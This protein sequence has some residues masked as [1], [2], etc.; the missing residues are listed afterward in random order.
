MAKVSFTKLG[1]KINKEIKKI[2]IKEQEV[3]IKQYL[4]INDKLTLVGNV[5]SLA[6]DENNFSNPVKLEVF[7][8][9]EIIFNY[10]NIAFTEKQKEDLVKLYDILKS[11][12]ILDQVIQ[13]IPQEEYHIITKAVRECSE[14]FYTYRNS[15]LG[16]LDTISTDYSN[17]DFDIN[18]LKTNLADPN[19]LTLLK[20][21]MDKLG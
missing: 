12:G 10:T 16:L 11:S 1:V 19:N 18:N 7:T 9:L 5:L 4:P 8:C 3:E 2:N 20:N 14:A 17:L 6:A 21:I 15:V 13:A